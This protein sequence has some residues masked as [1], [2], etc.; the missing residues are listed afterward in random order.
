MD[1]EKLN[2]YLSKVVEIKNNF[3]VNKITGAK[4]SALIAVHIYGNSCDILAI[5]EIC[6]KFNIQL[7]EDCAGALGTFSKKNKFIHVGLFGK[8]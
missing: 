6:E 7:I 2:I 1:P 5:A 3:P 8:I 4:I